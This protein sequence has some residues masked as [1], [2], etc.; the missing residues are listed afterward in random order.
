MPDDEITL[1]HAVRER[2]QLLFEGD[3]CEID[4]DADV[5]FTYEGA[6]VQAWVWVPQEVD[7]D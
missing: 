5:L 4:Q 1:R 6:W 2:A 3:D 7:D